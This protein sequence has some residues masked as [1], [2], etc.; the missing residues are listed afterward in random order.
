MSEF[1]QGVNQIPIYFNVGLRHLDGDK[2]NDINQKMTPK[3]TTIAL[4]STRTITPM[5][6]GYELIRKYRC[7]GVLDLQG[8]RIS[9]SDWNEIQTF[10]LTFDRLP[11][12]TQ[13]YLRDSGITLDQVDLRLQP[14]VI[15]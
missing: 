1:K 2:L 15:L 12:V 6:S 4:D 14:K 8:R 5:Q 13:I 10:I 9:L 3:L 7:N 11:P